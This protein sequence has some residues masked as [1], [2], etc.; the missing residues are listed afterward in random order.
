ML[1]ELLCLA[2]TYFKAE[3][4]NGVSLLSWN[5]ANEINNAGFG[6]ERSANGVNFSNIG[7]V[8]SKAIEG[9]TNTAQQYQFVDKRIL[10]K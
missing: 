10:A 1:Q 8:A 4:Q 2:V 3:L 6:I 7:F 9:N 5:T